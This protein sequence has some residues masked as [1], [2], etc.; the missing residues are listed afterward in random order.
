MRVESE[1]L[2]VFLKAYRSNRFWSKE[3]SYLNYSFKK[4]IPPSTSYT[5][6][7]NYREEPTDIT[8]LGS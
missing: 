2:N 1:P 3:A 7:S 6:T 4:R 5:Q 8:S